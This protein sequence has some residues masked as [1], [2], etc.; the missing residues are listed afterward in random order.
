MESIMTDNTESSREMQDQLA[1]DV[2][3]VTF[4]MIEVLAEYPED[5]LP[6]DCRYDIFDD[7]PGFCDHAASAGV[8]FS[9]AFANHDNDQWLEIV[10]GFARVVVEFAV[11][12]KSPAGARKL[13]MISKASLKNATEKGLARLTEPQP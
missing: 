13:A 3:H 10:E 8:A 9:K 6:S 11:R 5:A 7:I 12:T 4:A 1:E 2:A